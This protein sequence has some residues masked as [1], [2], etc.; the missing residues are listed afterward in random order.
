MKLT[1]KSNYRITYKNDKNLK[2][3]NTVI[4]KYNPTTFIV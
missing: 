1:I 2:Q 4:Q 3:N